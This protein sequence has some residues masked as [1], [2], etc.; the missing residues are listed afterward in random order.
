[1]SSNFLSLNPS[2]TEF[3]LTDRAQQLLKLCNPIIHEL[4]DVTLCHQFMLLA[5]LVSCL[6][7]QFHFFSIHVMQLF[8]KYA[9]TIFGTFRRIRKYTINHTTP[10]TSLLL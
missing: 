9:F 3:L 10:A 4:N 7:W 8:V 1:M 6:I 5:I 2:E